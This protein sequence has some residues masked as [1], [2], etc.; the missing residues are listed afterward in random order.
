MLISKKQY[1]FS[2]IE[3]LVSL[4]V[5]G[6]GLLGLSGLQVASMKGASNAHSRNVASMIAFEMSEKMRAN[7]AGLAGGFYNNSENCSVWVRDCYRNVCNPQEIA[8]FDAKALR[9]GARNIGTGEGVV[10]LLPNGTMA[11]TC[12]GGCA[13]ANAVHNITVTWT[14]LNTHQDQAGAASNQTI[15]LSVSP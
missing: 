6:I 10:T 4:V 11:I 1:G 7:P 14:E 8:R 3:V 15:T 12:V 2:M 5:A 9:C 13:Q